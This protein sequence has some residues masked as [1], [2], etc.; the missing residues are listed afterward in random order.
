MLKTTISALA[1]VFA[2]GAAAPAMAAPFCDGSDDGLTL[3]FKIG[4]RITET[5][6]TDFALIQLQRRGVDATRV[7]IWN[8]CYRAFVRNGSGGEEMQY[9]E[10]GS[11]R[12]V[13]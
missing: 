5:D 8:G 11:Y 9:F 2:L 4:G 12:R 13:Q 6:R 7:E 10:P 1:L 3:G